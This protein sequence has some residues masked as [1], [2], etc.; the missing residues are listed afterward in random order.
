MTTSSVHT[1]LPKI[2]PLIAGCNDDLAK[3]ILADAG[4]TFAREAD[5]VIETRGFP[6]TEAPEYGRMPEFAVDKDHFVP[7]HFIARN[8]DKVNKR[9]YL[10]YSLLPTADLMPES[11]IIRHYEA[12]TSQALFQLYSMPGKPW[13]SADMAQLYLQKYRIALGDAM[14]DNNTGGAVFDQFMICC[15][16]GEAGFI[17]A[18]NITATVIGTDTSDGNITPDVV[19]AGYKGYAK[20]EM[21]VGNIQMMP[22]PSVAD[23]VITVYA[24]LNQTE[25]TVAV[26]EAGALT[27]FKNKVTVPVGYVKSE[28]TAEIPVKSATLTANT[29]TIP[30]GYHNDQTLSVPVV[31]AVN[32]GEYVTIPVGYIKSEQKFKIGGNTGVNVDFVT[33]EAGDILAGKTGTDKSGN[34]VYGTIQT[35]TASKSGNVVTIPKGYIATAQTLTIDTAKTATVSGNVVTIYPGYTANQYT[36]TVAKATSSVSGNVVTIP[37]G[38][39]DATTKTVAE[40]AEPSVS[41]NVVTIPVG[42][43]KVQKTKTITEAGQTTVSGNVVTTPVGYV[44]SE[45][46]NTVGTAKG[47]ETITPGTADRTIAAGTYLTGAL[48]VKGDADLISENIAEGKEIFGIAGSFKGGSSMEFFKCAAVYG[49][50]KVTRIKVESAGTTAVNGEYEKTSLTNSNGG[51]VWKHLDADYYY[52]KYYDN[53]CID[54][55]YNTYSEEAL[56]Y[57]WDGVSWNSGYDYGTGGE[58]GASPAPTVSKAQVTIDADVPK[59]WDGYKAVLTDGFYSFEETLTTGLSYGTAFTPVVRDIYNQDA[60]IAVKSIHLDPGDFFVPNDEDTIILYYPPASFGEITNLAAGAS[61]L[62]AAPVVKDISVEDDKMVFGVDDHLITFPA[63][64]LPEGVFGNGE[65]TLDIW[66]STDW[67]NYSS[68]IMGLFGNVAGDRY[69]WL[70]SSDG[71]VWIGGRDSTPLVASGDPVPPRRLTFEVWNNGGTLTWT[72]YLNGVKNLEGTYTDTNKRNKDLY[73][74]WVEGTR[75]LQGTV[76]FFSIRAVADHKGQ[77]FDVAENPYA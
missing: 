36:A 2:V 14:R 32:D 53:W 42:Y 34:P 68:S 37:A 67:N 70:T 21:V 29:V 62:N 28:R 43:N 75:F 17:G 25:K 39:H 26:P 5:I 3:I 45:R 46:K 52:Y 74:G 12:I 69:D 20:G 35:V 24:G 48:T 50:R 61:R 11:V 13:T 38:Y 33:A 57:S 7:L 15:E 66:Y 77:S 27:V 51:E 8:E 49:P 22:Q 47:A 60:T 19:L 41:A 44:K 71:K 54:A 76:A 10:T 72:T 18:Q 16:P 31:S 30:E 40:M 9:V 1:L 56:Y 63:N 55:D 65:F 73:I 58:T 23:N 59:T 64:S 6:E 4:R